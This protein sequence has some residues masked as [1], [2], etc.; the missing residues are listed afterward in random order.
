MNSDANHKRK[1]NWNQQKLFY[2]HPIVMKCSFCMMGIRCKHMYAFSCCQ[3]YKYPAHWPSTAAWSSC[4]QWARK[5]QPILNA[6][7]VDRLGTSVQQGSCLLHTESGLQSWFAIPC[8]LCRQR[9]AV[10]CIAIALYIYAVT[11][12]YA[13]MCIALCCHVYCHCQCHSA[14]IRQ[15]H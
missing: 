1:A 12:R 4:S 2:I 14:T 6:N 8:L 13:V 9:Y 10:M 3:C 15:R 7:F 5:C 11:L